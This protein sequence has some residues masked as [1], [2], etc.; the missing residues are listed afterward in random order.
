MLRFLKRLLFSLRGY[1]VFA[2]LII[3]AASLAHPALEREIWGYRS[4]NYGANNIRLIG[5][6]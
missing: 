2:L 4:F 3:S 5:L 6:Q 1:S